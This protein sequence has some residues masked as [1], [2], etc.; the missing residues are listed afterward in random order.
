MQI[1][2]TARYAHP[3][4]A[5]SVLRAPDTWVKSTRGVTHWLL[6]WGGKGN[7]N[8]GDAD[9]ARP[10][11]ERP[12]QDAPRAGSVQ[13]AGHARR[14]GARQ[15]AGRD[16]G[17]AVPGHVVHPDPAPV[18]P[19]HPLALPAAGDS[20][21]PGQR[22]RA[23]CSRRGSRPDRAA[24]AERRCDRRHR[25]GRTPVPCTPAEL[26]LLDCAHAVGR[27]PAPTEPG[28]VPFALRRARRRPRRSGTRGRSGRHLESAGALAST[29]VAG[30][31]GV[32]LGGV[33]RVDAQ[34]GRLPARAHR[35][36]VR[37]HPAGMAGAER[38]RF[39]GGGRLD[40]CRRAACPG[41]LSGDP[42][43]GA[44]ILASRRGSEPRS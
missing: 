7:L 14:D 5:L 15:P 36:A 22:R 27:L 25:R 16:L 42:R 33:V 8:A 21:G 29:A 44:A 35:G 24:Q 32:S 26:P 1:S 11:G 31:E 2:W 41:G 38:I 23:R 19:V 3:E 10:D 12:R 28:L 17:R 18:R 20:P 40:R 39:A 34:R 37:R 13:G 6:E 4:I 30:P 43:A 9:M